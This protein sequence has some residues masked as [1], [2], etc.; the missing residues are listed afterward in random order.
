M[1]RNGK[2]LDVKSIEALKAKAK[3]YRVSD[4]GGLLLEVPPSGAKVWL[5]RLT[6]AGRRRDMGLG[7]YP[8]VPQGGPG[9]RPHGAA[10]GS[11][12]RS[13]RSSERGR[14][15]RERAALREADAAARRGPS[16]PWRPCIKAQA[17][18]WKNGRTAD[19]WRASLDGT[20]SRRSGDAGCRGGPQRRAALRWHGVGHP[21]RH[22]P[23]SAAA[24]RRRAS[25]CRGAWM[26]RQR[27][28]GRCA[29]A[30]PC[31]AAGAARRAQAT[32]APLAEGASLHEGAGAHGGPG[33]VGA[34]LL[35]PDRAPLRRSARRPLVGT[36]L[37][38]RR[39]LD[40]AGRADEGQEGG[41]RAAAPCSFIPGGV[42]VLAQAYI[43]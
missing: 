11:P 40:G 30:A 6:V 16:R 12:G 15:A 35:H 27:Q 7:G 24:H 10:N 42:A 19:L 8:A 25:L 36:V 33:A 3:T 21:P 2:P 4:G 38:W 28:P 41:R 23:Q 31:R 20:H 29:D 43:K 22:G 39:G 37:R 17:P 1:K 18:G 26:A 13:T 14:K 34:A 9:C 32:F 5:C